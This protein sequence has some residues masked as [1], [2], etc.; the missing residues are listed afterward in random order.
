MSPSY[1]VT[2]SAMSSALNPASGRPSAIVSPSASV[3][4]VAVPRALSF[5]SRPRTTA[6]TTANRRPTRTTVPWQS[7]VSP[8]AIGRWNSSCIE[9]VGNSTN[10]VSSD[11]NAVPHTSSTIRPSY[12]P[13]TCPTGFATSGVGVHS[14]RLRPSKASTMRQPSNA[15]RFPA[16]CSAGGAPGSLSARAIRSIGGARYSQPTIV[17][18]EGSPAV[19]TTG[20]TVTRTVWIVFIGLMIGNALS[21]LDTTVVATALPTIVGDLHG[22]RDLSWLATS[23]LLTAMVSTPLYGKLG[24]LYGRKRIFLV[25]LVLFMAGSILCGAAQSMNQLILF[26]AMQGLGAGGLM[27]LPFAIL[28]DLVPTKMLARFIGYSSL[29]FL[30]AS[31]GGPILGGVFAEHLSWRLVFYINVPLGLLS[32]YLLSRYLHVDQRRTE[33]KIDY[34]GALLLVAGIT[35]FVL[36]TSWGG[37][38]HA[39]GS[40]TIVALGIATVLFGVGFVVRER[41]ASEPVIP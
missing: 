27:S 36:M 24:D 23:Y 41:R 22:L 5:P 21:S 17:P 29:V 12:P 15:A 26:R 25:A 37:T 14:I 10:S 31:V 34:A 2:S 35:S 38:R 18:G 40:P 3:A 11:A 28:G 20:T 19:T 7:T 39:W 1:S 13:C 4:N 32:L 16:I 8:I 33:H 9:T 30:V 6:S